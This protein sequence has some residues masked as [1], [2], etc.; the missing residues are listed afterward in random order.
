MGK[1]RYLIVLLA[2]ASLSGCDLSADVRTPEKDFAYRQFGERC[3]QHVEC[4]STYCMPHEEGEFCTKPCDE[5]CPEG[6]VCMETSNPHGEGKVSLCTL[7][8]RLLCAPCTTDTDCGMSGSNLCVPMQ[9]GK[10]CAADCTYQDCPTGYE[11]R[12]VQ[13]ESGWSVRQ[14]LPL[15]GGCSCQLESVGQVRG[16][17]KTNEHGSCQGVEVCGSDLKWSSCDAKEPIAETCNGLDDNCN[18]FID[19][20]IEGGACEI[21]NEFG[22]CTGVEYCGGGRGMVCVGQTPTEEI[23]NGTD[24]DCDGAI[25]EDFRNA[26][27]LYA[28]KEH[29]GACGQNCDLRLAHATETACR[30]VDGVPT[31]RALACEDG[32][33]LY[34]DGVTCMSLPDNLCMACAQDEDCVGPDSLCIDM[35]KESFCGRDCSDASPYGGCPKG[36]VCKVVRENKKQCIPET[37]TCVCNAENVGSVRSC[38]R[39]TCEGFEWCQSSGGGYIW[40][41]CQVDAY[42]LEICDGIDNNCNGV[43]DE[44]M[45]DPVSGLYTSTQHCGYCFNDCSTYYKTEIHHTSGE[46]HVIAGTPTCGMGACTEETEN[47]ITYEWVNT[48]NEASN[49]CECRRVKGNTT[50]DLPEIPDTFA[51]GFPFTDE[52]CDGID[53][54]IDDAI[55]VS[56]SATAPGNGTITAPFQKISDALSVFASSGK[57]YILVAEGVYDENLNLPNGVSL[58]GGYS[59]NFRERDLVLHSTVLRGTSGAATVRAVKLTKTVEI[60]G[61]IIE[62]ADK[63]S[64]NESSIA[65]W[66]QNTSNVVLHANQISGG[67]G[68][69]GA[70]GESGRAGH[71]HNTDSKLDGSRGLD[72]LRDV[73]PCASGTRQN[74]GAGGVNSACPSANAPSGGRSVCPVYNWS[75]HMGKQAEYRSS[76]GNNGMGGFDSTFD[77]YSGTGCSHATESGYPTNILSDVGE[78]GRNGATGNNGKA[79]SGSS[80]AYGSIRNGQW[81]HA[82]NAGNGTA[83]DHGIAGGGGGAGG[84][85]AYYKRNDSDCSNYEI[86]PSGG[87]GGAGGCGGTGG[88]GGGA[89]GASIGLYITSNIGQTTL[90]DIS[91]NVFSRGR[92]GNGGDGGVGGA[93]G[94]GGMGGIGGVAGYWISTKA[95]RGGNGGTGGRGGGGGG[96]AGG[97]SFDILSF[98]VNTQ[99]LLERN[100]FTYDDHVARGGKGGMGGVGGAEETGGNG[101]NGASARMLYL[102]SCASSGK[103]TSGYACNTDNVCIPNS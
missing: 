93:G 61:F 103:C 12:D 36:Y 43:I 62:G 19:E 21:E 102:K 79:G 22:S 90:P 30:F 97:P 82:N 16:C 56:K 57:K 9:S 99:P 77:E 47:G 84:G 71:G 88:M 83:G 78:D 96:G 65:V 5:G 55:F 3:T 15:S 64:T 11:C 81:V 101:I 44:G 70:I 94:V 42:N 8:R 37:E 31:C 98:N 48:D 17:F 100:T 51:S 54:V 72:S 6:W 74:G 85:I 41:E 91:G 35:G 45:R 69:P 39:D 89:G 66:I 10:Y 20:D 63:T 13:D 38:K 40:G 80:N 28:T 75:T 18:G 95:G 25:D 29:C 23:C 52:N 92:G 33:F 26:D 46:C 53:G 4:E 68:G 1:F 58:Y 32:Y 50:Q 60:V 2:F 59:V 49:G 34:M 14:C 76:S 86:G 24:D 73:G 27:N 7:E 87:G 67:Q